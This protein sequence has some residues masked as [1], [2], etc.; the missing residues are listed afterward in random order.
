M[1]TTDILPLIEFD[2]GK[3][4]GSE[5]EDL[6]SSVPRLVSESFPSRIKH[7]GANSDSLGNKYEFAN[8]RFDSDFRGGRLRG[9][10]KSHVVLRKN[11]GDTQVLWHPTIL[12]KGGSGS[13]GPE[14]PRLH[15]TDRAMVL[16]NAMT[17]TDG[18]KMF[19][20]DSKI[21]ETFRLSIMNIGEQPIEKNWMPLSYQGDEYFIY[22]LD[23]LVL[24]RERSRS[25]GTLV[26]ESLSQSDSPSPRSV[27]IRGPYWGGTNLLP[28]NSSG[29]FIGFAHTRKPWQ[30]VPFMLN[31]EKLSV[32]FG[33]EI[34][35]SPREAPRPWRGRSVRYP[36]LL[37]EI[38]SGLYSLGIEI[39]DRGAAY[40][41]FTV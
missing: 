26:L 12:E 18:R 32:V 41:Q 37:K 14:D 31:M 9:E 16:F 15:V 6:V 7:Y 35:L 30:P 10:R 1:A 21:G 24:L 33:P 5:A 22:S 25:G 19:L 29:D 11:N 17:K 28:L 13:Y 3:M 8:P 38:G 20:H 4:V 36:F 40:F 27:I 34:W 2:E 39:E 23:P